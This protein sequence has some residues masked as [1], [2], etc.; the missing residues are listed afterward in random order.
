MSMATRTK[1]LLT[2][3][4]VAERGGS[5][6]ALLRMC[7]QLSAEGWKVHV[8]VPAPSPL[9]AEFEAAGASLHEVP[10]RRLTRSEGAGYWAGYAARWP[11]SVARLWALARRVR[12]SVVHSNSLHCW[13]GWAVAP[14]V[15]AP[16]LWHAREI[17]V[18]SRLALRVERVLTKRFAWRVAAV[19]AAVAAQLPGAPVVVVHDSVG[20]GDGF[21]P[22]RAGTWRGRAGI[23]D[24]VSLVGAAGR[25]DTWKGFDVLLQAWPAVR[26]ARPEAELVVAGGPVPGKEPYE[27]RL[28]AEA[29]RTEGVHWL[30]GRDDMADM[31]ADLDLFV[32][33]STEPEP[34]ASSA[35]EA[36]ASG[37]P[38]VATAHGGSPEML[39]QSPP[40]TGRLF[41]PRDP[42][43]LSEAVLAMLPA[44][45]SSAARRKGRPAVLVGD[46]AQLVALFDQALGVGRGRG[47]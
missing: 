10:M 25:I 1:T 38:V 28:A 35:V 4:P 11:V 9:A 14:L 19:S 12:P 20:P 37:C 46:R 5:D 15:R 41:A 45:P 16:H 13:Y 44:G 40:G 18:Q 27:A 34:F 32:L 33:P 2:V 17:V 31:M 42:A 43:A 8:V 24:D 47:Q 22:E 36:L 7:R 26:R 3:Q 23:A 21:A 30:G 29:R 6:Q 39:A